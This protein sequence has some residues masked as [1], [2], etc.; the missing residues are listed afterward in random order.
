M[1]ARETLPRL[2]VRAL[3]VSTALA[4][5]TSALAQSAAAQAQPA[6]DPTEI[7]VTAQKRSENLQRVPI[8]IQALTT[9]KLEQLQIRNFA[10][11][12]A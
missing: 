5:G 12:M 6:P 2:M 7:I 3:L 9:Q 4:S 8:S 11:Y 1:I 10:D